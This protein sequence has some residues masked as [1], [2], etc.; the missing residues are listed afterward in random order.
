MGLGRGVDIQQ[1]QHIGSN[2]SIEVGRR[3]SW[4]GRRAATPIVV[5]SGGP[6]T[7]TPGLGIGPDPPTAHSLDMVT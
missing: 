7:P 2:D 6:S 5:W 3:R 4:Y 1:Y